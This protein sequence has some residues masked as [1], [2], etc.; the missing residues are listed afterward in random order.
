VCDIELVKYD[1]AKY[2]VLGEECHIVGEKPKAARYIDDYPEREAY[3]NAILMCRLH[4]KIIDDNE[5]VYTI[6]I[7]HY[8][9]DSHEQSIRQ[10]KQSTILQTL[11]IEDAEF[12]T[13]VGKAQRAVGME[14][15]QPAQLRNVKSELRAGD[16][17]E[18]IGFS[19]NQGLVASLIS[20]SFCNRHFPA[21]FVGTPP[22]YIVCPHCERKQKIKH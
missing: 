5:N 13:I 20:C 6:E 12:L 21:A 9:K 18:A 22:E 16:V 8:M 4:H 11:M 7:L 19:T 17:Q 2:I 1:N 3:Y 10:A 14:I 15:N